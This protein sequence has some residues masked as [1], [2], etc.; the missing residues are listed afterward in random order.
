MVNE[1]NIV[2]RDKGAFASM[3]G[4]AHQHIV[5]GI[6]L[7]LG[8]AIAA[9]PIRTGA[10]DLIVTAYP[11][12]DHQPEKEILL[13]AQCRTVQQGKSLRLVGGIRGG[14][15]R[16]YLRPSPKEYKYTEEH[17]DLILAIEAETLDIFVVPTR[18]TKH[19]GKSVSVKKL[20]PLRNRFDILLNWND[21]ALQE[22]EEEV[23]RGS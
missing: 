3:L 6:L 4:E 14:V 7:R 21:N 16:I 11:D 20:E 23:L 10:Y 2:R 1:L 9:A 13:R 8:F 19:W 17:N 12:R 5:A 15:D 18:L 22:L